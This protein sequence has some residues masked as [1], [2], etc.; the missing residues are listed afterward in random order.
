METTG[1]E[2]PEG[3][4]EVTEAALE[5]VSEAVELADEQARRHRALRRRGLRRRVSGELA[6]RAERARGVRRLGAAVGQ[7][8]RHGAR[9]TGRGVSAGGRWL[10][11]QVL[12]M[13]PRLPVR[14]L[15]TLRG[16]FPHR[17]P[18][19]L[20][21]ALIE[22]AARASAAVGVAVGAWAVLPFLPAAGVEIATETLSVVGIEIKL[23]AELHEVYG[24]TA[25]GGGVERM[26]AYVG[27]WSQRRGVG[28]APGGIVLA[29]GSPLA[30][31]LQ[32]RLAA[33][34]GRSV[35]SLGPLLTGAAAG[36][37]INRR[38]TRKLGRAIRDDLRKRSPH[39]RGW[40]D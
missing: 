24:L 31:Q 23:V 35:F 26:T 33:R 22:G 7:A 32:R 12:A 6:G 2:P 21:E 13:A 40:L 27:A 1:S 4:D 8:A 17:T 14:N 20:A 38:E 3:A 37:I 36:G 39:A 10:S 25:P 5:A 18:D 29:A 11:D 15:A 30:R 9:I 34:A 19:E 16:Q 28:L